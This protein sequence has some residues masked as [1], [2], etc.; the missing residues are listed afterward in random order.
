MAVRLILEAEGDRVRVVATRRVD[1]EAPAAP[2][3]PTQA[4]GFYAELRDERE[5]TLYQANLSSQITR[6]VEV[7][8]P[9]GEIRRVDAPDE[10]RVVMV[11]APDLP[12]ATSLVVVRRHEAGA[13]T[14]AMDQ[15][16]DVEE[17][18][19]VDLTSDVQ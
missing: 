12:D 1:M 3:E 19:R 15:G 10:K 6:S 9:G 11:V 16:A 7:F 17:L 18:A 14:L 13:G 2:A 8:A 4:P 5:Q